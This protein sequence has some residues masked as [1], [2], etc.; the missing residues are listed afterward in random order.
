M[1]ASSEPCVL[2]EE[3]GAIAVLTL[4]RPAALNSFTR[5]M[6]RE[7]W[8]ALDR[9]EANKH[10]R[11]LV[12]TGAGRAFCAGA[13]LSEFDFRPG[14]DIMFRAD[15]GPVID[16]AFNPTT[17]R[18]INVRVPT[19]CAVNGVAA[20]AGA[21][22]AMACD[23]AIAAPGAS[24]IQA[25]SKIGLVPDSGG[26]WLL[27]QRIGL[28][29]AMA[30]AMTGDKLGA[31]HAKAMGMIWDVAEDAVAAAKAMAERLAAMPTKALVATRHLLRGAHTHSLD[32]QL[33]LERDVQSRLG[34]THDYI[35]GVNAFL[36]KRAPRFKGE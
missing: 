24:F 27:P 12:L 18:L 9:I 26:T 29:R 8:A 7:L 35:E 16:Q 34:F 11:A 4:N 31:Q 25:F 20:G 13:D 1:T 2:Y 14:D 3:D 10:I 30:L 36:Q 22:V 17:R 33:D 5:Q 21:S 32:E 28:A 15:P 19:I 23:I 6:H